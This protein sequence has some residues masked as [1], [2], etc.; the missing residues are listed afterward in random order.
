MKLN[1][2]ITD[3]SY[4]YNAA[5]RDETL[6]TDQEVPQVSYELEDLHVRVS[7]AVFRSKGMIH[8]RND[9]RYDDVIEIIVALSTESTQV[10][11][12]L[13]RQFLYTGYQETIGDTLFLKDVR[14]GQPITIVAISQDKAGE[15]QSAR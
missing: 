10:I 5:I 4:R 1:D 8:D 13:K 11:D 12:A 2:F 14:G 7:C 3:V 6:Q 9:P 15:K